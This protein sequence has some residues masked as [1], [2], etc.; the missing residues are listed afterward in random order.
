MLLCLYREI[1]NTTYGHSTLYLVMYDNMTIDLPE[2]GVAIDM[3]ADLLP[4]DANA[5]IRLS[6]TNASPST[7]VTLA[8][9]FPSWTT[10]HATLAVNSSGQSSSS[11]D[12][13][14]GGMQ[15]GTLCFINRT[16]SAGKLDL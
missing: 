9:R 4:Q 5:T 14:I 13:A 1:S 12:G 2:L 11:C 16:F 7:A 10:K 15:P 8:L 3:E 6:F